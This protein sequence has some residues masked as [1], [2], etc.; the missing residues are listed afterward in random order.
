M[1]KPK[2]KYEKVAI[3]EKVLKKLIRKH[4][5]SRFFSKKLRLLNDFKLV[6]ILDD[7]GSM[8]EPLDDSPLNRGAHKAT[9]WQELQVLIFGLRDE[10]FIF[11]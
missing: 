1:S 5:I 7:S 2:V 3:P 9:R 8:N 11:L 10:D 6:F 4:E